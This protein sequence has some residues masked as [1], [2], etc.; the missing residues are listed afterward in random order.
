MQHVDGLAILE[1]G[2]GG[3]G[4]RVVFQDLAEMGESLLITP[5]EYGGGFA[6]L[7]GIVKSHADARARFTGGATADGIHDHEDGAAAGGEETIDIGG[8]A[9]F[10]NSETGKILAHR[11]DEL[12]GIRHV[13]SLVLLSSVGDGDGGA[14]RC[15]N[16]GDSR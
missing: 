8:S 16:F 6:W 15:A 12:L 3:T 5:G 1:E 9:G 4:G 7:L 10:F 2:D 13:F 11:R 14:V